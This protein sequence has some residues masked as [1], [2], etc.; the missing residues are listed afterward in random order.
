MDKMHNL[1]QRQIFHEKLLEVEEQSERNQGQK[2]LALIYNEYK[3]IGYGYS[4]AKPLGF[5]TIWAAIFGVFYATIS[6]NIPKSLAYTLG[7]MLPFLGTRRKAVTNFLEL[8]VFEK[9]EGL[10]TTVMMVGGF[11]TVLSLL[12][13]F[14]IGLA[15][16]NRF[17][18]K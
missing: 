17:R 1:T 8:D 10:Q 2:S 9:N 4:I 12:L 3:A 13:L 15:L 5:L 16:R 6:E 11:Q 14:L 7:N 18:I